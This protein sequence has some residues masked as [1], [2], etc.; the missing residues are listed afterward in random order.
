MTSDVFTQALQKLRDII[1]QAEASRQ[2][3]P[4]AATLA[5]VDSTSNRPSVRTIYVHV[6]AD[7]I[8]FFVNTKTG[9]GRQIEWNPQIALC[10]F[11]RH[12]Q[13]QAI[14]EGRVERISDTEADAL[15]STRTRES[16]LAARASRPDHHTGDKPG[17]QTR[18]SEQKNEF[19][20]TRAPR[21]AA[22]AGYRLLPERFEFWET[23]WHRMRM[24]NVFERRVDGHWEVLAQDP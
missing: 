24:R 13:Q 20:F 23:G 8:A 21:P 3:E 11:W 19:S 1:H 2:P 4:N 18:L 17:L 22:W 6:Q 7:E 16:K 9:K 12:L 5:T 10:F 14:I 15:W